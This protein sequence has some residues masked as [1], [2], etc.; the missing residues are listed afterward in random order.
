MDNLE[1]TGLSLT[2]HIGVHTWEQRINQ[3]LIID[4]TFPV[5]LR[6]C[7][8][9]LMKTIDYDRV[10]QLVKSHVEG[11]SFRLI[12]TVANTVAHLIKKE[13]ELPQI[14][15]SVSKPYAIKNATNIKVTVTR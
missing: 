4:L 9:E 15:V 8:D 12:E 10:C 3:R 13:F 5:D 7:E 11:Q 14:T 2:T 1:I 6:G